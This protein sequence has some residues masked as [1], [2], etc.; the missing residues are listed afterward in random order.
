MTQSEKLLRDWLANCLGC[1]AGR[2][3]FQLDRYMVK[4]V[5]NCQDVLSAYDDFVVALKEKAAVACLFV[6][7]DLP[8]IYSSDGTN[9]IVQ[10][11]QIAEMM[12]VLSEAP[13]RDLVNGGNLFEK[14]I[15][16][17]GNALRCERLTITFKLLIP[18]GV[19]L[20]LPTTIVTGTP[21]TKPP[22]LPRPAKIFIGMICQSFRFKIL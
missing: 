17:R 8:G 3:E 7:D 10:I 16:V 22:L 14:K 20:F 19:R 5:K 2:R 21:T 9:A 11:N 13:T 6:L 18:S 4:A 15:L 12:V 1:V